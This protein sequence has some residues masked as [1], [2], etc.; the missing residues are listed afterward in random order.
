MKKENESGAQAA[1]PT[2]R[3]PEEMVSLQSSVREVVPNYRDLRAQL[4]AGYSENEDLVE[5]WVHRQ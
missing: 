4:A 3:N 5:Y 2:V 1:C